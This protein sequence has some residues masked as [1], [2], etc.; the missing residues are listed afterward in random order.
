MDGRGVTKKDPVALIRGGC[1]IQHQHRFVQFHDCMLHVEYLLSIYIYIYD[2]SRPPCP[3][4]ASWD[5]FS[6]PISN[7]VKYDQLTLLM[8]II[9]CNWILKICMW[10]SYHFSSFFWLEKRE[11]KKEKKKKR[12][13]RWNTLMHVKKKKKEKQRLAAALYFGVFE[14]LIWR[15]EKAKESCPWYVSL[16]HKKRMGG[17]RWVWKLKLIITLFFSIRDCNFI[18][19]C[20]LPL[21]FQLWLHTHTHI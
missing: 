16:Y 9:K 3:Y 1:A 17:K 20:D 2:K 11:K 18:I 5:C 13:T 4:T 14:R 12:K 10:S 7:K 21:F 8:H 6:L 15:D 19:Y